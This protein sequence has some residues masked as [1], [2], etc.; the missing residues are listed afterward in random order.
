MIDIGTNNRKNVKIKIN[1]RKEG[2]QVRDGGEGEEGKRRKETS[3]KNYTQDK[4]PSHRREGIQDIF[5]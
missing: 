2:R 5:R 3:N 1:K 4:Y